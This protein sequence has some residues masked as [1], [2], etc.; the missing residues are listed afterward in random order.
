M[1]ALATKSKLRFI[2]HNPSGNFVKSII[3]LLNTK[4]VN[5]N[6]INIDLLERQ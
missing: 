6:L 1:R 3:L 4:K 5:I 2:S